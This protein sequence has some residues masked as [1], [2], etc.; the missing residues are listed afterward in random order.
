MWSCDSYGVGFNIVKY[1]NPE[2]DELLSQAL[3]ELD[4][5]RRIELYTEFQNVLLADLPMA[6]TDFPQ[7]LAPVSNLIH[8]LYPN[9]QNTLFNVE[10]W[11]IDA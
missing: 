4:R 9:S 1:C 11:W 7:G 2:V 6:V 10:T 5:E 8:N 3:S